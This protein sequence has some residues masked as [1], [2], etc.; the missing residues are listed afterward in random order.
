MFDQY[1]LSGNST[2]EKIILTHNREDILHLHR[3][4]Y[5]VMAEFFGS[6]KHMDSGA[7]NDHA[8]DR[9]G[10]HSAM[11]SYGFPAADGRLSVR[12]SLKQTGSGLLK[13]KGTQLRDPVSCAFFPDID[14]PLTATFSATSS[15]FEIDAPLGRLDDDFYMDISFFFN[16]PLFNGLPDESPHGPEAASL[17]RSDPDCVNGFLIMN[18]RTINLISRILAERFV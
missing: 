5:L 15:S 16:N 10:L 14:S 3:L 18:P 17:L 4:M 13:I 2:L 1:A 12:P 6:R 11:A 8:A 7:Q 9:P